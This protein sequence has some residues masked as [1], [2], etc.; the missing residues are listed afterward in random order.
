MLDLERIL[1]IVTFALSTHP[2]HFQFHHFCPQLVENCVVRRVDCRL[3]L[4]QSDL[5]LLLL[6]LLDTLKRV[7]AIEPEQRAP[8]RHVWVQSLQDGLRRSLLAVSLIFTRH[9]YCVFAHRHHHFITL[10]LQGSQ[11]I[12]D[13]FIA[14]PEIPT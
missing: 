10:V 9:L 11:L 6:L 8:A 7:R 3:A 1:A 5:L 2:D 4:Q 13:I 14:Q 12:L